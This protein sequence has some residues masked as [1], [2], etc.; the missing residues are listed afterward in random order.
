MTS[1][2]EQ[3]DK[4]IVCGDGPR[5]VVFF[6]GFPDTVETWLPLFR[7]WTLEG[8]RLI[9]MPLPDWGTQGGAASV[10]IDELTARVAESIRAVSDEPVLYVGHDWGAVIGWSLAAHHAELID[11]ALLMSVPPLPCYVK[12]GLR[13]PRQLFASRYILG[14]QPPRVGERKMSEGYVEELWR[15]WSGT[16]PP[17]SHIARVTETLG[18]TPGGALAYY[19]GLKRLGWSASLWRYVSAPARCDVVGVAGLEDRCVRAELWDGAGEF[20]ASSFRMERLPGGGHWPHWE[21]LDEVLQIVEEF[22]LEPSAT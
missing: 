6:H 2:I 15:R 1:R 3:N 11:R 21:T 20:C 22:A 13:S 7:R 18:P 17:A 19:R 14:F 12:N 10:G 8:F 4:T 5:T 9:A 16:Q